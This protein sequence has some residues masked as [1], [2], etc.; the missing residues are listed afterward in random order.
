MKVLIGLG[1]LAA[2]LLIFKPNLFLAPLPVLVLAICPLS[3]VFMMRGMN[4][5]Q[6]RGGASCVTGGKAE[7]GGTS[8]ASE[9]D[10]L[11][12]Q[13]DA[14]HAGFRDL[15]PAQARE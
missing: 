8:G 11:A 13:I 10:E 15:K 9:P 2:G 6:G 5:G 1:T 4:S 12:E 14:L 3:M 7:T